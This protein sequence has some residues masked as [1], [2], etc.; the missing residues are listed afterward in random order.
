MRRY[1]FIFTIVLIILS[2]CNKF[3]A[4]DI[5][6]YS[7]SFLPGECLKSTNL[8]FDEAYFSSYDGKGAM[9]FFFYLDM[10]FEWEALVAE[11]P[12]IGRNI[13]GK[14]VFTSFKDDAKAVEKAYYDFYDGLKFRP[15]YYGNCTSLYYKDGMRLISHDSFAEYP[16]EADLSQYIFLTESKQSAFESGIPGLENITDMRLLGMR[17]MVVLPC[18]VYSINL[19]DTYDFTFEFPVKVGQ[20]LHYLKDKIDDPDAKVHFTDEVLTCDFTFIF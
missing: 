10:D 3:P 19:A 1:Y 17:L 4:A 13:P 9:F 8:I 2:S 16:Q 11:N 5:P 12:H 14:N 15:D 6:Y 20:Y 7:K 18:D